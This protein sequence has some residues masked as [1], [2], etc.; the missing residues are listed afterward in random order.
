MKSRTGGKARDT[1]EIRGLEIRTRLGTTKEERDA[2]Q[3]VRVNVRLS[4]DASAAAATD[5]LR[6]TVDWAH[7]AHR[8]RRVAAARPRNLA[9]TLAADICAAALSEERVA[10]AEATVA[11]DGGRL[12]G[13]ESLLATVRRRRTPELPPLP[14]AAMRAKAA[15]VRAEGALAKAAGSVFH[16]IF[17][18]KRFT[19]PPVAPPTGPARS[20]TLPGGVPRVVWITNFTADCTLPVFLNYL[21]NR[22]LARS[23]EFR[24]ADDAEMDRYVRANAPARAV[25]AWDRLENGAARADFWRVFTLWREGGVYVDMDGSFVRRLERIVEGRG[26]ALLWDRR[27]FSN[28][29]MAAAPGDPLFAEFFD[30]I[31]ENVESASQDAQ[32]PVFYV[33][34]PGALETVLDGKTGLE[35]IPNAG[36][37]I[38]GAF[39][40]ERFQYA[41]RPGSK[42]TRNPSFLKP[43]R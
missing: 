33:T 4:V 8:I 15:A 31:V 41:D 42:W 14:T 24:F 12:P 9:E 1:L 6:R 43:G 25:A 26:S 13:A 39:T 37:C 11:K 35:F 16:A 34:G 27:R 3:T 20:G 17:P 28:F 22:C 23:F 38:Q 5:E 2:P 19:I 18:K 30:A 40:N 29:F 21:R 32:K 36:C 10:E 7:L